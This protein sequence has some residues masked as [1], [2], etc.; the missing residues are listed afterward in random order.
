MP[1]GRKVRILNVAEKPSVAREITRLLSGGNH[2]RKNGGTKYNHI[3]TFNYNVNG[4]DAEMVMTSIAGHLFSLD[5]EAKWKGWD[6]TNPIDLLNPALV[7]VKKEVPEGNVG[8]ARAL[9]REARSCSTLILWLDCDREG[10]NIGFEV[11]DVCLEANPHMR[12][13]RARFSAVTRRDIDRA[14]RTLGQPNEKDA[15]AVDARQETDLRIGAAFT[16]FITKHLQGKFSGMPSLISYG[17]CQFPT[18]GFVVDRQWQIDKFVPEDFWYLEMHHTKNGA[19]A[20]FKWDRT[21]VFDQLVCRVFQ[22]CAKE[23]EVAKI[24]SY[25]A[26]PKSKWRPK[27]LATID[28]QKMA[29]RKLRM[30]SNDV[31][32]VAESLYQKGFLSYPRTE[33]DIFPTTMDLKGLVEIQSEGNQQWC[34]YARNLLAN[35]GNP[36][37]NGFQ[38]PRSGKNNDEAHPPIHPTKLNG[39]EDIADGR[40]LRLYEMIARHFL[41][42]CSCDAVGDEVKIEAQMGSEKFLLQGLTVRARNYLD[43]YPYENWVDKP[44]PTYALHEVFRPDSIVMKQS[45]TQPPP[46]LSEA[47]LLAAMEKHNIGT[48]AT[49]HEHI[50]KIKSRDYA[51]QEDMC[52][53]P[54]PLGKGLVEGFDSMSFDDDLSRPE[55]RAAMERDMRSICRGEKRKEEVINAMLVRMTDVMQKVMEEKDKLVASL[56]KYFQ[57]VDARNMRSKQGADRRVVY[58]DCSCSRKMTVKTDVL[59]NQEQRREA[60]YTFCPA[61]GTRRL[62]PPYPNDK[63]SPS[64]H[65]CPLCNAQVLNYITQYG[66][67]PV[68]PVCFHS[69]PQQALADIEEVVATQRRQSGMKCRDCSY[70]DCALAKGG[71]S[72]PLQPCPHCRDGSVWVTFKSSKGA[73]FIKCNKKENGCGTFIGLPPS[74]S[75]KVVANSRCGRCGRPQLKFNFTSTSVEFEFPEKQY[76]GCVLGCDERL[77][78]HVKVIK[79]PP[80]RR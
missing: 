54:N 23:G 15:D 21:R 3:F 42:C 48:D 36:H 38:W 66:P 59:P 71:L 67:N 79:G 53:R 24:T 57:S 4:E 65:K 51:R 77:N 61:C 16:R 9:Q 46:P 35:E 20:V 45:R 55:L 74:K 31:M 47:D 29:A 50:M 26:H 73:F 39:L 78:P 58:L 33:T 18:L 13:L 6:S 40:G 37:V 22:D 30:S 69:P 80:L 62:P 76:T 72:T 60:L 8:L 27:P 14:L 75:I 49:M 5:F 19:K 70:E 68:C 64:E 25:L 34:A 63:L 12:V 10:E 28:M 52:Y 44:I 17:P 11:M 56:S 1:R 2:D 41:A 7:K 32:E 43:V